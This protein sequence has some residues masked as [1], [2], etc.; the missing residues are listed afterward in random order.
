V[1]SIVLAAAIIVG[2]ANN[3]TAQKF[4]IVGQWLCTKGCGPELTP[5]ILIS[6]RL[7]GTLVLYANSIPPGRYRDI[8][9]GHWIGHDTIALKGLSGTGFN[10]VRWLR[11]GPGGLVF[12]DGAEWRRY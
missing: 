9:E 12:E 1:R 10:K 4:D 5:P 7:D 8:A 11:V 3:V 2:L 6:E